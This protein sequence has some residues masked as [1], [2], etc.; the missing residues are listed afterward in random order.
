VQNPDDSGGQEQSS[1]LEPREVDLDQSPGPG[2]R[3]LPQGPDEAEQGFFAAEYRSHSGP[4]P[5]QEWLA[6]VEALH[7]GSTGIILKDFA[8]ERQHQRAMQVK[9]M[10][11]DSRVVK[12]FTRYQIQRLWI[13]GALA[14]FLATAGIALILLDKEIYGFVLLIAEVTGLLSVFLLN[15]E[16]DD[17]I[18][19][20][21]AE[22][23][24]EEGPKLPDETPD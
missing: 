9:A 6:S 10:D 7:P 23:E 3:R 11:L 18:D 15:R 12:D 14:L 20:L 16:H 19:E 22:I 8:D 17:D 4:L 13:A 5:S 24:R 21:L 2:G 1:D